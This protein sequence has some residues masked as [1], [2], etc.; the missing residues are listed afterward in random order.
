VLPVLLV[1]MACV[2][3]ASIFAHL[4]IALGD[5]RWLAVVS[6]IVAT[7][8][9]AA[10]WAGIKYSGMTGAALA[11]TISSAALCLMLALRV[12]WL[13]A[14]A[15][16]PPARKNQTGHVRDESVEATRGSHAAIEPATATPL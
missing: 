9:A 4:E 1:G 6:G 3:L 11:T 13:L 15:K 16:V 14:R 2:G 7:A 8:D 12:A 5:V 10:V